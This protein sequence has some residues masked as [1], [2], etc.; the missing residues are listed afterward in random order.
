MF[1]AISKFSGTTFATG[2]T[3]AEVVEQCQGFGVPRSSYTVKGPKAR[4][5][6]PE[7]A[8]HNSLVWE[9]M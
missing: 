2:H 5:V 8:K 9:G 1:K 7:I 3:R 4:T 6:S